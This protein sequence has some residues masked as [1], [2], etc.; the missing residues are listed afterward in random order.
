MQDRI[1]GPVQLEPGLRLLRAPNPSPMTH[2]GTNTYILGA[3]RVAVIDPGPDMA[4]HL[5]AILATLAKGETVSHIFV[6]HSHLDHSPLARGLA[7]ATGAPVLAFGDARAGRSA[8]MSALALEETVGGGEGIDHD[9]RPDEEL[10]DGTLV[11]GQGWS[12]RAIHTPGHLGNHLCFAWGDRVFSGDH[13]MGWASS[14]V[15]PP[16]GDMG[17][18]MESLDKLARHGATRLYPG[19]GEPVENPAGRIAFL[20]SHRRERE[21]QILAALSEG[22][23]DAAAIA[24]LIYTDIPPALLGAA[25]R[26]VLAHL[27]DLEERSL[28]APHE[29]PGE[30]PVFRRI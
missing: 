13:V 8:R 28:V 27:V 24:R 17:A 26:N 11:E 9:F 20:A 6:T 16:D 5:A 1:G 22:Q 15:S 3:G 30:T 14:L 2:T 29:R 21:A 19:H 25:A 23:A 10:P 12:L 7:E 4:L 18:Y